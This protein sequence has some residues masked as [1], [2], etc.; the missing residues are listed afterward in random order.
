MF[1]A[2][3]NSVLNTRISML[4]FTACKYSH[5]FKFFY[6]IEL[7]AVNLQDGSNTKCNT[8]S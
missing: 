6:F 8:K 4:V 3:G 1:C 5:L 2:I 7:N